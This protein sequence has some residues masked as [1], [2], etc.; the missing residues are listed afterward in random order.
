MAVAGIILTV[1]QLTEKP[2]A[3]I[4]VSALQTN[5]M[6]VQQARGESTDDSGG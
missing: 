3:I 1:S 4:R 6:R 5:C 2:N